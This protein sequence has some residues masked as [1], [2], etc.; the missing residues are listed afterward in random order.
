VSNTSESGGAG[1]EVQALTGENSTG[2]VVEGEALTFVNGTIVT[3]STGGWGIG[4]PL[5]G[6]PTVLNNLGGTGNYHVNVTSSNVFGN[7]NG[8]FEPTLQSP[9]A[10]PTP[11]P[12]LIES[13]NSFVD[14]LLDADGPDDVAGTAD[15][16]THGLCSRIG[17]ASLSSLPDVDGDDTVSAVDV[18]GISVA[19]GALPDE[20]RYTP[21]A[22]IDG[23][24]IVDG[25]DLAFVAAD[26]GTS[27]R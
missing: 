27:C 6:T 4:G 18:L 23:N 12:A 10:P 3:D 25:D 19:F 17:R 14:P 9:A 11:P 21:N 20:P 1:I 5:P 16:F 8:A 22:D 7:Q 26:V 13:G 2:T 15:D 24:G